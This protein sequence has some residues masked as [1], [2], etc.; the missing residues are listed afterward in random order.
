MQN[1]PGL[2][3]ANRVFEPLWNTQHIKRVEIVWEETL[4]ASG[5]ASFYSGTGALRDMIQNHLLQLLALVAM[6]PLHILDERT[7]RDRKVDVFRAVRRL[8]NEEVD[9]Y[10]VRGR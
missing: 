7:L 1:I 8:S 10:T 3:F 2:R 9:K 6:E 5:R 4:T